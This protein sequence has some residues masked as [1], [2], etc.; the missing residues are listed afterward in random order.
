MWIS[1]EQCPVQREQGTVRGL[2]AGVAGQQ[3]GKA[4]G[5]EMRDDGIG[6]GAWE[7]FSL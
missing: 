3:L 2:R 1:G 4:S 5:D 6:Q 7:A